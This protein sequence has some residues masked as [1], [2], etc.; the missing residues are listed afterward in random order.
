MALY[1]LKEILSDAKNK[2]Y[3]VIATVAFNFDSAEAIIKAAEEKRSPVVLLLGEG[4]LKYFNFDRLISPVISMAEQSEA[5]VVI[6]LDHCSNYKFILKCIEAGFSSVMFDGS[7]LPLDVNIRKTREISKISHDSGVSIEGE[8]G[9]VKGL[10][11]RDSSDRDILTED[12][13]KVEDAVRFVEETKVDAL[14][15]AVG[16][17]HGIFK[18]K[19][20]IDLNRISE[21]RDAIEAPLVLHGGSGLTDK[22]FK[23]A[24]RRGITKINYFTDILLEA[25]NKIE[26]VIKDGTDINFMELNYVSMM[27]IKDKIK[28]KMDVFGSSG[29]A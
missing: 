13:T 26:Q 18:D 1:D 9:L 16:T 28:E 29:K 20:K 8:V 11:G 17:I 4:I 3:A 10:E 6:H 12:Y 2:K 22:I 24:I 27:A 5:T 15:I 25:R 19:P 7:D 21:I 14:A 23:E